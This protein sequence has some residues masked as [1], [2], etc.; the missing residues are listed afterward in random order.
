MTL[1]IGLAVAPMAADR[2]R[3]DDP[4]LRALAMDPLDAYEEYEALWA[5]AATPT[6]PDRSGWRALIA[7][8]AGGV[9]GDVCGKCGYRVWTARGRRSAVNSRTLERQAVSL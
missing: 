7:T 2:D 8:P 3:P 5:S 1:A 9:P 4:S 6:V